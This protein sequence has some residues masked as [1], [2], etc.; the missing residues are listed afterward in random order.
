MVAFSWVRSEDFT[1]YA[2]DTQTEKIVAVVICSQHDHRHIGALLFDLAQHLN[3]IHLGHH[4]VERDQIRLLTVKS[5]KRFRTGV[6]GYD[7]VSFVLE[8]CL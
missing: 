8:F 5:L 4:D 6:C 7:R 1:T 2:S 3:A